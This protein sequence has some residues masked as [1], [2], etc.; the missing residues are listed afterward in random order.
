M[1]QFPNSMNK[2]DLRKIRSLLAFDNIYTAPAHGFKDAYE[3]YKKNSSKPFLSNI[4]TPTLLMNSKNDSFLSPECYP[5]EIA[6]SSKFIYLETPS[7]GGH[8]GFH[9]TNKTYYNELRAL[10][11]INH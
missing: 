9:Q 8:V 1:D 6:N 2:E 7:Y 4:K 3:Y 5:H 11:F 10:E